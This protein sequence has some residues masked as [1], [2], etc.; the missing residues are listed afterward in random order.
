VRNRLG[1]PTARGARRSIS[2]QGAWPEYHDIAKRPWQY[3]AKKV[4]M[5]SEIAVDCPRP[6]APA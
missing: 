1:M 5:E 4:R 6:S 2:V 3:P